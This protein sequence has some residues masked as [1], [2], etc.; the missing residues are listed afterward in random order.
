MGNNGA[1]IMGAIFEVD[2]P[3]DEV[4][5]LFPEEAKTPILSRRTSRM[6]VAGGE[7]NLDVPQSPTSFTTR[8]T[9]RATRRQSQA[10]SR[11]GISRPPPAHT[12]STAN[13]VAAAPGPP[14]DQDAPI[15]HEMFDSPLIRLISGRSAVHKYADA[16]VNWEEAIASLKRVETLLEAVKETPV[17]KL[18]EDIKQLQVRLLIDLKVVVEL[19]DPRSLGTPNPD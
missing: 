3:P 17:V 18:R 11:R 5:N 6:S 9:G 8:R 14:A 10:P 16:N 12:A 19:K 2:L 15:Q 4:G 13:L 7:G 1:N